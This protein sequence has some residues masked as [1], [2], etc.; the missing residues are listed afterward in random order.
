MFAAALVTSTVIVQLPIAGIV[1]P[2]RAT[3]PPPLAA[4]AVPPHVVAT[5]DGV[6]LTIPAG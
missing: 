2:V 6:A 4:V 3:E 1:P 5:F